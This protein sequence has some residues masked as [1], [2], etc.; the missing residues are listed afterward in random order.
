MV[1]VLNVTLK[2]RCCCHFCVGVE[3]HFLV[4]RWWECTWWELGILGEYV[5]DQ[6]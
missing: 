4:V 1:D 3:L 2:T 5:G 6:R